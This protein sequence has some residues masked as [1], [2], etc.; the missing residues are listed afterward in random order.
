MND[1]AEIRLPIGE[2]FNERENKY[3]KKPASRGCNRTI[4]PQIRING[5]GNTNKIFIGENTAD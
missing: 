2:I 1:R 5:S 3:A 4:I